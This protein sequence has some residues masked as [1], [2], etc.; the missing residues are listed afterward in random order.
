MRALVTGGGGFLGSGIA[1]SLHEKQHD[2]TVV[3]RNYYSH[4]PKSIKQFQGDIRDF[5]FLSKAIAGVD[6][7]FTL[8]LFPEFGGGQKT[9]TA[10]M[11][12]GHVIL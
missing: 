7:I 11:L 9:F 3:G 10:S 4:L 2:V 1:K 12:M 5:D 6:A 8:L